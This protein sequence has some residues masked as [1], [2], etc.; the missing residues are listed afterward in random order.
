MEQRSTTIS[1]T[2]PYSEPDEHEVYCGEHSAINRER[3][4][5]ESTGRHSIEEI[6]DK[7]SNV[8]AERQLPVRFAKMH[9]RSEEQGADVACV[10]ASGLG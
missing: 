1:K 10:P 4:L 8:A 5:V 6:A 7:A 2:A 9:E 3:T